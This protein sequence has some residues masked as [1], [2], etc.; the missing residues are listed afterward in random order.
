MGNQDFDFEIRILDFTIKHNIQKRI[1]IYQNPSLR[2]IS[3][4]KAKLGFH[5]GGRFNCDRASNIK[6]NGFVVL[7][8]V[9]GI[10]ERAGRVLKQQQVRV[11]YKPQVTINSLFPRPKEQDDSDYQKSGIVYKISCMQ[12]KQKDH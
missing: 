6:F 3:I 8:C 2:W 12:A 11:S 7:P 10:S 9:Q 5:G 1:L 4:K